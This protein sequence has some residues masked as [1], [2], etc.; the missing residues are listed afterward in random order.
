MADKQE[1]L[2][3]TGNVG[4]ATKVSQPPTEALAGDPM[5]VASEII[6]QIQ[7]VVNF[8]PEDS[9]RLTEQIRSVLLDQMGHFDDMRM[10]RIMGY[11]IATI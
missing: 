11:A 5:V 3:G 9:R 4:G 6:S 8:K 7:K 1:P 10:G 2:A